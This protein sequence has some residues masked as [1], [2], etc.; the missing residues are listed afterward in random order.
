MSSSKAL[1]LPHESPRHTDPGL[2]G[3]KDSPSVPEPEGSQR[4]DELLKQEMLVQ[5]LQDAYSFSQKITEAIGVISKMMYENTTTVVQEVI[6]FFVMVFQFGVP[7]ALFGVRRMLPLIWSKELGVREAVLNA[8]R[9]LYL[10]PKGDSAR[11]T[12]QALIQNLS[13]LLVDA[14]RD[15]SVS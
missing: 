8:Y 10:S 6:E 13:L 4:D 12:A 14:C 2:T 15:H 1:K 11:A 5:Y 3:S 7:Q 9:Q